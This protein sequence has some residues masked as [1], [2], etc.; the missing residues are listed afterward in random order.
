MIP[1]FESELAGLIEIALNRAIR[2]DPSIDKKLSTLSG[3]LIAVTLSDWESTLYYHFQKTSIVVLTDTEREVDVQMTGTSWDFFQLGTDFI[4][5]QSSGLGKVRFEGDIQ[6]G[7]AF[8]KFFQELDIDWEEA[9]ADILGDVLA[10]RAA[11]LIKQAGSFL[12]ELF[13]ETSQNAAE[14]AQ[15]ELRVTP[16]KIEMENFIEDVADLR[17]DAERLAARFERLK[18]KLEGDPV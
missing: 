5:E 11:Q 7:Q 3:K 14:Y 4:L 18:Q 10:H 16:S 15:E 12:T 2:L 9:L 1:L 6:T 13:K 17:A 8:Q